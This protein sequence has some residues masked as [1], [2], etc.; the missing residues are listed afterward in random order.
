M[1]WLLLECINR[2]THSNTML[3]SASA[4]WDHEL[5]VCKDFEMYYINREVPERFETF[6]SSF[7][8]LRNL[9]VGQVFYR[10]SC[11]FFFC[12]PS[13]VPGALYSICTGKFLNSKSNFRKVALFEDQIIC[14]FCCRRIKHF[15]KSMAQPKK[16]KKVIRGFRLWI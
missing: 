13:T 4:S 14:G 3:H 6:W 10:C 5:W 8:I 16:Q 9:E 15:L 7:Y 11:E 2:S 12:Q 1:T